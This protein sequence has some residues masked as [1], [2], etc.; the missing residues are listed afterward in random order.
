[1]N[2]TNA[3]LAEPD[4][5]EL[6]L[7][8]VSEG[9]TLAEWCSSRDIKFRMVR[10]WIEVDAERSKLF[11][12]ASVTRDTFLQDA[13]LATLRDLNNSDL[14]ELLTDQGGM[15]PLDQI[16]HRFRRLISSLE[17][18]TRVTE[19]GSTE[20][21]Q[22]VRSLTPDKGADMLGRHL[23]MYRDKMEVTGKDGSPLEMGPAFTDLAT[24]LLDKI[25]GTPPPE[26]DG[27]V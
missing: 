5:F 20:T 25:R 18:R 7:D 2:R 23:G 16:P 4:S 1:M 9:G 8:H 12:L 15:K 21:I 13:V 19:D 17:T 11:A 3:V 22:K 14:T 24:A 26:H 6:L 10:E 27:L